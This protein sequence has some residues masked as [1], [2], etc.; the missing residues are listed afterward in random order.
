[1]AGSTTGVVLLNLGGPDT[2]E[3]IRPFLYN[4]FSDRE[5]IRLGPGFM[6][7]PLAW[8]IAARRAPKT[9]RYYALIGG[10][11]PINAITR[12]QGAALELRLREHGDFRVF[13]AMRYWH[14]FTEETL[15]EMEASGVARIIAVTLYPQYSVATTGSS[16]RALRRALEARGASAPPCA[17]AS[18]WHDNPFYIEALATLLGE[19]LAE[20][21]GAHVLFSA[22]SLPRKFIDEGDPYERATRATAEAVMAGIEAP[23]GLGY[24]SKSGPVEWLGPSTEDELRRLAREGVREVVVVPVSFVS[25]HVETLYEIDILYKRIAESLGMRLVRAASLNTHPLFIKALED[26]TLKK[27]REMA[28]L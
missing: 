3:A 10:G 15:A 6:Q 21:P 26:V 1:M 27:A 16:E 20:H 24:Q 23:W 12:A 18:G 11:S 22:H 7:R 5:I 4:L 2:P 14:P 9:A 8:L 28:W 19:K 25:D 17:S 13:M